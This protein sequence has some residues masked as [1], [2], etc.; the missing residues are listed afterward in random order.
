MMA[1]DR[2]AGV[3]EERRA[4]AFRVGGG[5]ACT[6]GLGGKS[7]GLIGGGVNF[8]GLDAGAGGATEARGLGTGDGVGGG[9]GFS[10]GAAAP[11]GAGAWPGK[12]RTMAH[13]GQRTIPLGGIASGSCKIVAHEGHFT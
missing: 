7:G 5:V 13:L 9:G 11:G 3:A 12:R 4:D 1:L 10:A 6:R 2:L 8:G